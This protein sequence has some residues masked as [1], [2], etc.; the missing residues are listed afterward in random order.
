MHRLYQLF[1]LGL[2]G[3]S[4]AGFPAYLRQINPGFERWA[5]SFAIVSALCL[6]FAA[7]ADEFLAHFLEQ[8]KGIIWGWILCIFASLVCGFV[9]QGG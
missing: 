9:M 5:I 8:P 4:L 1:S 3:A 2:L 7:L 6:L